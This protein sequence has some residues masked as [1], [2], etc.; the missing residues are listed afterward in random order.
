[1][2]PDVA[3][4][5]F[6][7]GM[8]R[9]SDLCY[10]SE[11]WEKALETTMT[12]RY[13]G[14]SRPEMLPF[15]PAR[16]AAVL[17]IGCG[18]GWFAASIPGT[19]ETW[20]VEPYAPAAAAAKEHLGHVI[21]APFEVAAASLP[22]AHFDVIVCNDVMEH[23]SDHDKFLE[24]LKT[25][26]SPGGCLVA[27]IPN[28]RYYTNLFELVFAKDWE[29]RDSGILDRTHLRFFTER[30]LRRTLAQHGYSIDILRGI[31]GGIK[32]GWGRWE[33]M[34]ALAAYGAIG[35]SLGAFQD[36]KHMQ[37]A[38]RASLEVS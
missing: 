13:R 15:I 18:E 17:E 12:D 36:I 26:I 23:V 32:F 19:Q 2:P 6:I 5:S 31:N 24:D 34:S 14:S 25:F 30:S 3:R 21:A 38:V 35:L 10:K 37:L 33:A 11:E 4:C 8:A 29:Y 7:C 20:G 27:S 9:R 16:R 1:M 28:A 22:E